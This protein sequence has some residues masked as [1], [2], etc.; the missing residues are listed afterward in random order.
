MERK[1]KAMN[2][3]K[4]EGNEWYGMEGNKRKEKER[5]GMQ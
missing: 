2:D 3:K 5:H 1:G 4:S